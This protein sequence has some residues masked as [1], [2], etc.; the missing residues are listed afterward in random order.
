MNAVPMVAGMDA[1]GPKPRSGPAMVSVQ[2]PDRPFRPGLG[3]RT[4]QADKPSQL[5]PGE[6]NLPGG[7]V[8]GHLPEPN[9]VAVIRGTHKAAGNCVATRHGDLIANKRI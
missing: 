1:W 9:E 3:P 5:L 2:D 8:P 6:Y 7:F 4:P